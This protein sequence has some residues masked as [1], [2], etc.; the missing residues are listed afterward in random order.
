MRAQPMN[1]N[2]LDSLVEKSF[3]LFELPQSRAKH[4]S[5]VV[6]KHRLLSLGWNMT[7]KTHP[8]A[9]R[10]GQEEWPYI[11]SELMAVRNFPYPP[12][13]LDRC[14]LI[15]T[16]IGL[17]KKIRMSKPCDCCRRLIAAF[18]FRE[19]WYTGVAGDWKQL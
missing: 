9:K 13:E 1:Q 2:L 14:V 5:F 3:A 17:D 6:R 8:M 12:A 16:R 11:H 10:F 18:G 19:V 15:N 4:F 7:T